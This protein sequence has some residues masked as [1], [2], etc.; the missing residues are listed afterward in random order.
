MVQELLAQVLIV[1]AHCQLK[2]IVEVVHAASNDNHPFEKGQYFRARESAWGTPLRFHRFVKPSHQP[3]EILDATS[4]PDIRLRGLPL[5]TSLAEGP[6][7]LDTRAEDGP[8]TFPMCE[9]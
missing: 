9:R 3:L 8:S 1:D 2:T 4:I 7:L 5:M 6:P